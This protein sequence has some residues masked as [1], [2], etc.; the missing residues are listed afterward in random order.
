MTSARPTPTDTKEPLNSI[1]LYR[2]SNSP[3]VDKSDYKENR[4]TQRDN[5][6]SYVPPSTQNGK[7]C[8]TIMVGV[9]EQI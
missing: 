9:Y 7:I 4:A 6:L 2:L 8:V 5:T 3:R 1:K